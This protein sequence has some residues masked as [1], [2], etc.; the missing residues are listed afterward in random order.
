MKHNDHD[1]LVSQSNKIIFLSHCQGKAWVL[2]T[3]LCSCF[4]DVM[5]HSPQT[6]FSKN[7]N[8]SCHWQTSAKKCGVDVSSQSFCT[9][10]WACRVGKS[11]L[12]YLSQKC[13]L[14]AFKQPWSSHYYVWRP[15]QH[16]HVCLCFASF[17]FLDYV[18]KNSVIFIIL[19]AETG[20]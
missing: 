11:K 9:Q 4:W 5:R 7:W 8:S 15:H 3:L 17:L 6:N 2:S 16:F 18:C 13:Q 20:K 1:L 19:Q 10:N 14:K 12:R